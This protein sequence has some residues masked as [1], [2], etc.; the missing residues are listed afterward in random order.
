MLELDE[1]DK[2]AAHKRELVG[3]PVVQRIIRVST[4]FRRPQMQK[5]LGF[6]RFCAFD[7]QVGM[8]YELKQ[9][10]DSTPRPAKVLTTDEKMRKQ[11]HRASEGD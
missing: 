8:L 2:L 1:R 10:W 9:R 3:L 5:L 4:S 7:D 11:Q 6:A